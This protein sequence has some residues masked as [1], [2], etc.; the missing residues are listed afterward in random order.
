MCGL[1]CWQALIFVCAHKVFSGMFTWDVAQQ[2]AHKAVL[3][4]PGCPLLWVPL[5]AGP[6]PTARGFMAH[7]QLGLF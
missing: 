4:C 5:G 6:S 2:V 1:K 7:A 3:V